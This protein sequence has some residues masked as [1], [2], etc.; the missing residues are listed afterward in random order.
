MSATKQQPGGEVIPPHI[1]EQDGRLI[2]CEIYEQDIARLRELAKGEAYDIEA[3]CIAAY[4]YGSD[5]LTREQESEQSSIIYRMRAERFARDY[6]THYC[7]VCKRSRWH[8]NAECKHA[9]G[10]I[11]EECWNCRHG[12]YFDE[13]GRTL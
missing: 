3:A 11:V 6:H 13:Y 5:W 10:D 8:R 7:D 4:G 12:E 1:I 2:N 9:P